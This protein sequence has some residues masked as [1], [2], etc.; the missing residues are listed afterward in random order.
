MRSPTYR[1]RRSLVAAALAVVAVAGCVTGILA[2]F[3]SDNPSSNSPYQRHRVLFVPGICSTGPMAIDQDTGKPGTFYEIYRWMVDELGYAPFRDSPTSGGRPESDV[4]GFSYGPDVTVN[5]DDLDIDPER[6]EY[7]AN[8]TRH[9]I[10]NVHAPRLR[11]Y[12]RQMSENYPNEAFDIVAHSM[13]GVVA[14]YTAARYHDELGNRL[15]SIVTINSPVKG[16]GGWRTILSPLVLPCAEIGDAAVLEMNKSTE[17]MNAIRDFAWNTPE[18]D[19]LFVA[20]IANECDPIVTTLIT[21]YPGADLGI[22]DNADY[23]DTFVADPSGCAKADLV[24]KDKMIFEHKAP[25]LVTTNTAAAPSK[26]ALITSLILHSL[27]DV[28][29]G[30]VGD[31]LRPTFSK[32]GITTPNTF[33]RAFVGNDHVRQH[34]ALEKPL[35]TGSFAQTRAF[36]G[37]DHVRQHPALEK[38]LLTGSF[39]QTRAF[40]GNG[41]A[42]LQPGLARAPLAVDLDLTRV[43]MGNQD[44][45]A[46]VVLAPPAGICEF[47]IS[48]VKEGW[49]LIGWACDEPGDPQRLAGRLGG[50]VRMLEWD[51]SLQ[52]FAGSYRSD[53]AFNT[54]SALTK[55]KA[56]W[57]YHESQP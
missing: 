37:N 42:L 7:S 5:E 13:G 6:V 33:R 49:T 14:L 24:N 35:L 31:V 1:R 41:G 43:F 55:W 28:F 4:Y 45:L 10:K 19:S 44:D 56:Y 11:E 47:P 30:T 57:I 32:A 50:L 48:T 40:L 22:V 9:S 39:A 51:A 34:S 53:R 20:T 15:H 26:T 21:E 12:L 8:D 23:A 54:L 16:N 25:L 17:V 3:A 18:H 27:N 46:H 36:L 2:A 38:P 29:F 52:R